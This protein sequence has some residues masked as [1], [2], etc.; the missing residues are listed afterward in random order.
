MTD[1]QKQAFM[2]RMNQFDTRYD[3]YWDRLNRAEASGDTEKANRYS[4]K[5]DC[6]SAYMDGMLAALQIFGHTLVP[7][8]GGKTEII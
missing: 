1:H 4:A 6:I 3:R 2:D 7:R 5:M 8:P